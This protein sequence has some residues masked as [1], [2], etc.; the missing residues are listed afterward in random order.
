[1]NNHAALAFAR[2]LLASMVDG[3]LAQGEHLAQRFDVAAETLGAHPV[4]QRQARQLA[5]AIRDV[6]A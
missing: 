6:S 3:D 5:A 2:A 4:A 1:M